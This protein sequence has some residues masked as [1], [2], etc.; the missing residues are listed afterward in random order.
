MSSDF[1]SDP[2][3]TCYINSFK[4]I[5]DTLANGASSDCSS[6]YSD[7]GTSSC[8]ENAKDYLLRLLYAAYDSSN[9]CGS[10]SSY[11]TAFDNA[12]AEAYWYKT[13]GYKNYLEMI[14]YYSSLD[15]NDTENSTSYADTVRALVVA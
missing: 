8:G 7:S 4:L 2:S 5:L 1:S 14:G 3:S 11:D 10:T 9:T 15:T 12:Y 13:A 6:N